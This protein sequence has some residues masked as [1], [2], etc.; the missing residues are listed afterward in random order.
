MFKQIEWLFFDIGSTLVDESRANE[1]RLLDAIKGTDITYDQAYAQAIQLAKQK[2]AHPLKALGL[3]LTPWHSEDETVY[4]QAVN[5]L[6]EL[7]K[8]YKLGIIANQISGTAGRM[9]EY[10]LYP[11][12]DLII[13]SAEEGIEKPDL[14]IFQTA[15]ERANCRP[16]NA[17]MI[18][19]RIDNDIVPA[20]QKGMITIWIRQGFGG[21]AENLTEA[22]TPDYCVRNLQEL[23]A[24]LK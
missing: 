18:G 2:N 6:A 1:H 10:G 13:A 4:P 17:A 8:N 3:P 22:E 9:K 12:L 23:L 16:E 20:K 21:M 11:Y 7:H 19:D 15:L 24:L 14:R 5:C